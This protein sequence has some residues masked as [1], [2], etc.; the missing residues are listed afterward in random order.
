MYLHAE[1]TGIRDLNKEAERML[2]I[3]QQPEETER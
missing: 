1:A 3:N 2:N